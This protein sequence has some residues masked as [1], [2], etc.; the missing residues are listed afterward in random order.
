MEALAVQCVR[1]ISGLFLQQ[2]ANV[3]AQRGA[4]LTGIITTIRVDEVSISFN[5][6]K[7]QLDQRNLNSLCSDKGSKLD[8]DEAFRQS[9]QI[10]KN[11]KYE[12]DH[13]PH[14]CKVRALIGV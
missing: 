7:L 8:N 9:L 14:I 13:P 6:V 1:D 12:I 10:A 4:S 2:R 11:I 5:S 3:R